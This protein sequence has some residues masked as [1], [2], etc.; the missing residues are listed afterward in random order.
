MISVVERGEVMPTFFPFKSAIVLIGE[1]RFTTHTRSPGSRVGP[2]MMRS[3]RPVWMPAIAAV[4][5]ISD[6][7]N[8][9]AIRLRTAVPPP[10][11][12]T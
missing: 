11:A 5:D 2:K 12:D 4:I 10:F 6:T 3:G 1:S 9:F 8:S 7:G